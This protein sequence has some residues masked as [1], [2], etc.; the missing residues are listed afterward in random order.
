MI[1]Q[2]LIKVVKRIER[3]Q[4]APMAVES[5]RPELSA[6]ETAIELAATVTGWINE[7]R[8]TRLAQHHEIKQQLG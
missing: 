4:A 6:P 5:M 2:P 1:R 7:F 3:E 8:Q